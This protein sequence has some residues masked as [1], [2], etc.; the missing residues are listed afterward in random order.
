MTVNYDFLVI[1]EPCTV[2]S[3]EDTMTVVTI[4]YALGTPTDANISPY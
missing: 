3:F 4:M 1:V 2:Q